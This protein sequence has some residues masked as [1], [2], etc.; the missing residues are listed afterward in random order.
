MQSLPTTSI[1]P[2]EYQVRPLSVI[3]CFLLPPL[4]RNI[5]SIYD[6]AICHLREN[7]NEVD[8][9]KAVDIHRNIG[10]EL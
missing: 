2:A 1:T 8:I 7:A 4:K 10:D 5:F 6:L 9:V 3:F